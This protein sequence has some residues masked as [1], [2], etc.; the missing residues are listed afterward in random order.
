[1]DGVKVAEN[2]ETPFVMGFNGKHGGNGILLNP[3]GTINDGQ[4]ELMIVN[5]KSSAK[6]MMNFMDKAIKEG[7][8]H[9]YDPRVIFYRGKEF[10]FMNK[11]PKTGDALKDRQVLGIDGEV[12]FFNDFI[13]YEVE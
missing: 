11:N 2:I 9:G 7:G 13:K 3:L 4:M 1:M 10:K 5:A 6:D 12:L 8:V